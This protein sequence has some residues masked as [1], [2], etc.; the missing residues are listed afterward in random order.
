MG[1]SSGDFQTIHPGQSA[2]RGGWGTIA[3]TVAF[4]A[5]AGVA[6]TAFAKDKKEAIQYGMGL[7]VNV[8]LP[9]AEVTQVV[10]DVVQNGIIR[11]TKEYNNDE[12]LSGATSVESTRVFSEWNEGGKVF[13]KVRLKAL[14]PR[15]FKDTTD[16]GTVAVRYV[17]QAQDDKHTILKID[18]RFVEDFRHVSHASDG[19]VEGAEYKLIPDKLDAIELMK[20]Q[21]AESEKAKEESSSSSRKTQTT[22]ADETSAPAPVTTPTAKPETLAAAEPAAIA[23]PQTPEERLHDL[24]RQVERTVKSPGAPL[25]AAPFH[26]ASTLQSLPSG[27]EVLVVI[28]TPYWLGIETHAGQHGWML[29]DEL[30]LVP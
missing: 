29:R 14:D 23:P 4:L 5:L 3:R 20:T 8:P 18:A 21:T 16:A 30:E 2:P 12:Y 7:I 1:T 24:R 26:S 6:A 25:K 15:N 22:L 28:T 17:V 9:A 27:T 13:Y 11:G 19:S 10:Q